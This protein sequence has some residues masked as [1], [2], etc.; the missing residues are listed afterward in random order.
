MGI[1]FSQ[2]QEFLSSLDI[3]TLQNFF[4]DSFNVNKGKLYLHLALLVILWVDAFQLLALGNLY[5]PASLII[6]LAGEA[7]ISLIFLKPNYMTVSISQYSA[8]SSS[9][10]VTK[11]R[12]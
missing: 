2:V 1:Y 10:K 5:S 12:N 3:F 11:S 9:P 6:S 8:D 7:G 4:C